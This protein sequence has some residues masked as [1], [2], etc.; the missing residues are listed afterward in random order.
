MDRRTL[1]KTMA[2]LLGCSV[3]PSM[4]PKVLAESINQKLCGLSDRQRTLLTKALHGD[5]VAQLWLA[6]WRL[7]ENP[8][9]WQRKALV[10]LVTHHDNVIMLA[11]RG[12]G[13]TET[14]SAASYGEA[15][16]GG[17]AMILSRSD[18]QAKR[19][20]ERAIKHHHRLNLVPLQRLT[21]HELTFANGGRILAL[22]CSAD[23]IVGEHGITLLG[24]D[25]AARVKDD[26]YAYVTPML[27]M[28][29]QVTGIKPRMALLSTPKGKLGFFWKEWNK[30]GRKDWKRHRYTW[31]ESPI[32]PEFIEQERASHGD[33]FIRQEYEC[34]F[35]D[36]GHGFFG[37]VDRRWSGLGPV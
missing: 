37:D 33:Y 24:I 36:A 27:G 15:C 28:S 12:G 10:E 9:P 34:E 3:L 17:F 7:L 4:S 2:S 16:L 20:V 35:T 30:E 6:P 23:T 13:K 29:E 25:E 1:L 18:R 22:P 14:F 5:S 21:M 8:Y 32:T 31:R 19:V 11:T 26:F